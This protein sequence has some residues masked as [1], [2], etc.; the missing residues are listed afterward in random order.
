MLILYY[1]FLPSLLFNCNFFLRS[2]FHSSVNWR[3]FSLILYNVIYM[4]WSSAILETKKTYYYHV[5]SNPKFSIT[6]FRVLNGI[7]FSCFFLKWELKNFHCNFSIKSSDDLISR[8]SS[9][10]KAKLI[11]SRISIVWS[12]MSPHLVLRPLIKFLFCI[13][14]CGFILL[15]FF[16]RVPH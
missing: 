15:I 7:L 5:P 14:N 12:L 8:L 13:I 16:S 10:I 1:W 3:D 6:K 4:F 9:A 2:Y 11:V